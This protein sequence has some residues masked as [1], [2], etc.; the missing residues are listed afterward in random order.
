MSAVPAPAGTGTEDRIVKPGSSPAGGEMP[1]GVSHSI[2]GD[3]EQDVLT[4]ACRGDRVVLGDVDELRLV[5]LSRWHRLDGVLARALDATNAGSHDLWGHLRDATSATE[6]RWDL[7]RARLDQLTE[8]CRVAGIEV[9][10]L[11]GAA[12][13]ETG[14]APP[15]E[16]PMADLDVLVPEAVAIEAHRRARELGFAATSSASSWRHATTRHHHLPALRDAYGVT[17]E[18][19]H[20][21]LDVSH[22]Q[23]RLDE[24]ARQRV[25]PLPALPAARLDDVGTWLHLAV[26]FWDDRRR[27][28][29]GP[30]LQLLDLHLVLARLDP[31]ELAA[32]AADGGA[33]RLVGTVAS[34]LE[35]V[36]PSDRAARLRASLEGPTADAPVI[37]EFARTRI[38]GR[39]DPLPQLL[40]PTVDV[41][42]TP[43]RL[44][45]RLRHQLWPGRDSLERVHGAGAR[46]RDHLAALWP[47][48]R[49]GLAAPANTMEEMRLDRWAH[50][51]V[52]D[53]TRDT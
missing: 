23:S 4:A 34:V 45:T 42:Y 15:G 39:R 22:P 12:L 17:I 31:A 3:I 14:L 26:H 20:R 25:Q 40:H 16:R 10:L 38:F 33:A 50:E 51:V 48:V 5:A 46:R 9:V 44:A 18:L 6:Q 49:S 30:L 32:V 13:V 11:K 19:H 52:R 36:L 2:T 41:A 37:T 27:G 43:L 21:L 35:H 7:L 53:G 47:V 24:L 29:G 8:T 1:V 28:T